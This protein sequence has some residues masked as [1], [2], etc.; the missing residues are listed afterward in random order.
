MSRFWYALV[1][2][3]LSVA[4]LG[5]VVFLWRFGDPRR[6]SY[7]TMAW[8]IVLSAYAHA[9]ELATLLL[10]GAG[11]RVPLVYLAVVYA[12]VTGWVAYRLALIILGDRAS[13]LRRH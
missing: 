11:V 5:T 3:E 9:A 10:I 2:A 6:N 4:L 7:P 1:M 12:L 13:P 8:Y